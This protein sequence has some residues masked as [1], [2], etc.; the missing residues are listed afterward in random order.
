[1]TRLLSDV[2]CVAA[3]KSHKLT[4]AKTTDLRHVALQNQFVKDFN[5]VLVKTPLW[6]TVDDVDLALSTDEPVQ[7]KRA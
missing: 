4:S 3:A 6:F 1:M 5:K 2:M 7:K